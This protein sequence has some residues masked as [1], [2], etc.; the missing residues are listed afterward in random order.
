MKRLCLIYISIPLL[1]FATA[2]TWAQQM[3]KGQHECPP[4]CPH[5]QWGKME[6]NFENLRLLKL[7]EVL[8]LADEQSEKFLPLFN[9]F[10]K[11]SKE[12]HQQRKELIDGLM[13]LIHEE[14][15]EHQIRSS[16]DKLKQ[17]GNEIRAH[18]EK[19]ST[20]CETILSIYQ[21][22]RLIVFQERFEREILESLREF[23]GPRAAHRNGKRNGKP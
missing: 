16:I 5:N 15:D 4:D 14:G 8:D 13:G 17:N 11:E 12:L 10:R 7:L 19:F 6:A 20:D 1:L 9:K 22:A 3:G 18:R 2:S 21:T 23:R